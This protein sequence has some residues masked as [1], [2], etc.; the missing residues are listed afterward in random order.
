MTKN[1]MSYLTAYYEKIMSKIQKI[2][3]KC[4]KYLRNV[5]TNAILY[6]NTRC[7]VFKSIVQFR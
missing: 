2:T 5:S 3:E 6:L 4:K 1:E 7:S